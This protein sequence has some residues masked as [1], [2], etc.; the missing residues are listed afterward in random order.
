MKNNSSTIPRSKSIFGLLLIAA[1]VL[2]PLALTL[3]PGNA[4]AQ[5]E[6]KALDRIE[7]DRVLVYF[8]FP[9]CGV[10]CPVA[11][12]RLANDYRH[13]ETIGAA[14]A[15][16]VVIIN[17]IPAQDPEDISNY[18]RAYHPDF[19]GLQPTRGELEAL[20]KQLRIKYEPERFA[21]GQA[22]HA[23]RVYL[24]ERSV[25]S[26]ELRYVFFDTTLTPEQFAG[27]LQKASLS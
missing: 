17:L 20:S 13:L 24:F 7:A 18:A 16:R 25:E 19:V 21:S 23:D 14:E 4:S 3:L 15:V 22:E 12:A 5:L 1:A 27:R 8:A 26:W 9:A 2:S 11:L 6:S 10:Q